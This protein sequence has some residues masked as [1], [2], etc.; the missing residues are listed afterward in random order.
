MSSLN[1][2]Y[3]VRENRDD[4]SSCR[5]PA[6]IMMYERLETVG[7]YF[8]SS[9]PGYP[10]SSA[11]IHFSIWYFLCCLSTL[12]GVWWVCVRKVFSYCGSL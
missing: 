10:R 12:I 7:G 5:T 3:P 2:L 8:A 1:R 6:S 9:V 4:R 11:S